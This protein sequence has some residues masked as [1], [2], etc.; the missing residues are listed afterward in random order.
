M[1]FR[2]SRFS[3]A[4]LGKI[5]TVVVMYVIT[6]S[7]SANIAQAVFSMGRYPDERFGIND[8]NKTAD[9]GWIGGMLL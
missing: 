9:Y 3:N 5:E 8:I 7:W 1:W 2:F 6:G 4:S